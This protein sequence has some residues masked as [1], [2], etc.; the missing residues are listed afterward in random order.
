M[1]TGRNSLKLGRNDG[2]AMPERDVM[3]SPL[4][5]NSPLTDLFFAGRTIKRWMVTLAV[6]IKNAFLG[7]K[8]H[9]LAV[10]IDQAASTSAR[11][12]LV[13]SYGSE[14]YITG[15]SSHKAGRIWMAFRF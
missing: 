11:H 1:Q 5:T 6:E 3:V 14:F 9:D 15:D 10:W 13:E 4:P 12:F 2:A 8:P 7:V